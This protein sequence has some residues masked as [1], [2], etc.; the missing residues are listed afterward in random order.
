M[1]RRFFA[2]TL[3]LLPLT[4]SAQTVDVSKPFSITTAPQYPRPFTQITVTPLSGSLSVTNATM[5][6]EVDGKKTYEGNAS[7]ISVPVGQLGTVTNI[8]VT[9][10]SQGTKYPMTVSVRPQ[11]LSLI[12]EP[13]S[14]A[15][16]LYLGKG[17]IPAD[18]S[19]RI[20]AV[21]NLRDAK[22]KPVQPSSISYT[23]TIDDVR[24]DT[25]SGIGRDSIVVAT[26]QR[27]RSSD[28]SVVAQSLDGQISTADTVSL[29]PQDSMVRIYEMDPLLGILFDR[30]IGGSVSLA[31]AQ[32]TFYGAQYSF[33]TANGVPILRWFLNGTAAQTG[34]LIT[35]RPTGAGSG[36]ASLSLTGSG[37]EGV[38]ANAQTTV[39]FGSKSSGLGIFGL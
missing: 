22:N 37:E 7:P 14:S 12:V 24:M 25:A 23:W 8:K 34:P 28:I 29:D 27:Y 35:L 39:Q 9:L 20:V 26:P 16:P 36:S 21:A 30:A 3:L 6:V 19:A 5:V 32:K 31:A 38:T 1:S 13:N 33:P 2:L 10:S 11:D 4:V 18:G 17:L 15:P